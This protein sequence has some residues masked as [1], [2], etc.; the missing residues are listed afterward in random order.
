M[1]GRRC[2]RDL[3]DAGGRR[4][5]RLSE[6]RNFS[7][8]IAGLAGAPI[9]GPPLGEAFGGGAAKGGGAS[10]GARCEVINHRR[11]TVDRC[12]QDFR[13]PRRARAGDPV[14]GPL[15]GR[16]GAGAGQPRFPHRDEQRHRPV[17]GRP[18]VSPLGEPGHPQVP[19]FEQVFKN[20]LTTLPMGG[21]KGGSDF[22]PKG[23]SDNEVMRF[24]QSFMSRAVPPYRSQHGRAR[25][26]HRRG[27]PRDRL[28]VRHVQ[29]AEKRVRPACS[30][31][32]RLNWGGSLI[33][34]EATGY[35]SVYFAAE[36]LKTRGETWRARPVWSP[37]RATWPSTPWRSCSTS[38]AR[39]GDLLR[40]V[41]LHR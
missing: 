19:G 5:V 32:R 10:R 35:G 4:M 31:A 18:A 34:P 13:A 36:M 16:P 22:D 11:S 15:G 24:C 38:A 12:G 28:P 27:R 14:P 23:K 7:R 33:R 9:I 1:R 3:P 40:F 17:Q 29:E 8:E 37:A 20:A 39:S 30:P 25:R 41:G 21:G 26:R 6:F 2:R